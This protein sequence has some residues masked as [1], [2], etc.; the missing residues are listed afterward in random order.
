TAV[1]REHHLDVARRQLG[2][3]QRRHEGRIAVGLVAMPHG[4]RPG[5]LDVHFDALARVFGAET[6]RGGQRERRLVE[7]RIVEADAEGLDWA[8]HVPRHEADDGARI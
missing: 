7:S 6:L 5:R 8:I 4:L 2:Y 1:T 3:A